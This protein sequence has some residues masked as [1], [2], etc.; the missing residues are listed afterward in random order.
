MKDNVSG[1]L[2]RIMDA[3]KADAINNNNQE[4]KVEHVVLNII[5]DQDNKAVNV[6]KSMGVDTNTLHDTLYEIVYNSNL[7]PKVTH[8]NIKISQELKK[9]LDVIDDMV[10]DMN[11]V[12]ADTRHFMLSLLNQPSFKI[13][14][15][16][17]K[18]NINYRSFKQ[19]IMSDDYDD[20]VEKGDNKQNTP[21]NKKTPSKGTPALTS[22]C[23]DITAAVE[24]G[25]IDPV[26]GR[27]KE[28]KRVSQILARRKKRNPILIGNAGTGKTSIVEGIAKM[29]HEGNAP[30]LLAN[31]RI[32]SLSLTSIVAGTK[33]RGQFEERMKAIMDELKANPDII[34][35]LDELHTIVGAGN[36]SGGLDASNIFKPALANGE[37]QVIGAT[38]LDEFRENIEKD[39]ALTR[40][41]QQVLVEEPSVQEAITILKNVKNIY[42][43]YH[44]VKYTD[45]AVEECVKMADRYITD[46]SLPDKAFDIL[47]EAGAA[48]NISHEK[49]EHIKKLELDRD[50][51]IKQKLEVV[52]KQKYE[53]A[54]ELR[55]KEAKLD[56]ALETAITDWEKSLDLKKTEIG[57]EQICEVISTMTGVP[58]NKL[59]SQENKKL[60]NMD[61][62]LKD[63]IIG[64]DE[65]I[66]K[67]VQAIKRNRLGI[68]D[69]KKPQG[70]FIYLGPSGTGKTELTKRVAEQLFGD[71]DSLIRL[72]MSEYS[73]KFN[74][75]RLVGAPPG[76]VGYEQGGQLT[77]QVRRKPY[78]VVLFDEIEK[79]HPDIYNLLLQLLDEGQLTDGIGRKIDFR[80]CL[81]IMTS[82]VGVRELSTMGKSVGFETQSTIAS[83]SDRDRQIIEKALKKKFPP[84]FLN[85][86]D[87]TIV[88]N[89]LSEENIHKIIYVEIDKLK[90]RLSDMGYDIKLDKSAMEFIAKEGYHDEYGA[91]PLGRA[92][93]VHIGNLIA[94]EIL[95]GN[96]QEGSQ[97]KISFD[98]KENKVFVKK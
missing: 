2:T 66:E 8:G 25:E 14:R 91:R 76:Y 44:K 9:T 56:K 98:K 92:I 77:E 13:N 21:K 7:T 3:A 19:A 36:S 20:T 31:K 54:A 45:E 48:T 95:M 53:E 87:E 78:S 57:V 74:V 46:R 30:R 75:S 96:I 63:Y 64:Q 29:I 42:E 27:E 41:F 69:K 90:E 84:E 35:F 33:Y 37:I 38:T 24:K 71:S 58:L 83:K 47:D 79:A 62:V 61:K 43:K 39:S 26:I 59:S 86:I 12:S 40:R 82:N 97:I 72:D 17:T 1:E 65:A 80:N 73:E 34:I 50:M 55:D 10:V 89:K 28:I 88:F 16:L 85:R 32:L 81:I 4:L 18:F 51:L 93:Q 68:K 22:F 6:I 52:H 67:T 5:T 60:L 94:D 23:R 15:I 49:P 11:D 70:V